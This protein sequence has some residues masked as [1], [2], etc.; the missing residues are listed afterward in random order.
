MAIDNNGAPVLSVS[1]T[2]LALETLSS[3]WP[4]NVR[5]PE[6][7]ARTY[8]GSLLLADVVL[9]SYNPGDPLGDIVVLAD[10]GVGTAAL[11]AQKSLVERAPADRPRDRHRQLAGV[12]ADAVPRS[13]HAADRRR[14]PAEDL[15]RGPQL[16]PR[17]LN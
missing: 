4:G 5:G 3:H 1:N 16:K 13:R 11:T 9:G 2:D 17:G 8:K 14:K 12:P 10:Y 7:D 15:A 6:F